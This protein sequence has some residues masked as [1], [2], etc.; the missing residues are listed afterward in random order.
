MFAA[1]WLGVLSSQSYCGSFEEKLLMGQLSAETLAHV[2]SSYEEDHQRA[3]RPEVSRLTS[4]TR[5][6]FMSTM[7]ALSEELRDKYV[8]MTNMWQL[9]ATRQQGVLC[10]KI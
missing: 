2:I 4:Q 1:D 3:Q 7:P 6:R 5:R 9:A 10:T 8:V